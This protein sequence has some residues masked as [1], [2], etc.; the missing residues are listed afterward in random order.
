MPGRGEAPSLNMPPP[1]SVAV[2]E[3]TS[4]DTAIPSPASSSRSTAVSMLTAYLVEAYAPVPTATR[5][6]VPELTFTIRPKPCAR[7]AGSTAWV[8]ASKLTTLSCSACPNAARSVLSSG[9]CTLTPALLTSPSIRWCRAKVAVTRSLTWAGS[10]TSVATPSAPPSCWLS[11]ASRSARRAASTGWAPA[12]C[13]CR[14]VAA[15]IPD[16]APVTITVCPARSMRSVMGHFYQPGRGPNRA[17]GSGDQPGRRV[18]QPGPVLEVGHDQ[19]GR[20][21]RDHA[22]HG[23]A[24]RDGQRDDPAVP[25]GP[26]VLAAR[27]ELAA[28][29]GEGCR[30]QGGHGGRRLARL[31]RE[32]GRSAG[33]PEG[34]LG[35]VL[36]GQLQGPAHRTVGGHRVP[37]VA[38]HAP[39]PAPQIQGYLGAGDTAPVHLGDS[40]DVAA[41][42]AD[43]A[44]GDA[45]VGQDVR[46]AVRE[47]EGDAEH[48]QR[49]QLAVPP[50]RWGA[51][52]ALASP[53]DQGEQRGVP[54]RDRDDG[55]QPGA[56]VDRGAGA[57]AGHQFGA[58]RDGPVTGQVGLHAP[59]A[60]GPDRGHPAVG[61]ADDRAGPPGGRPAPGHVV[62]GEA[63]GVP[64]SAHLGQAGQAHPLGEAG[65]RGLRQLLP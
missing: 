29:D 6:V 23:V 17:A 47:A 34:G 48:R 38:G 9:P 37:A 43:A 51:G 35:Q 8:I 19:A 21:D 27:S 24:G 39:G 46:H 20:G 50:D 22:G 33:S 60:V 25:P 41:G 2:T 59:G 40:F 44:V 61:V 15:P 56:G 1:N 52:G 13:S 42:V 30:L 58:G 65:P 49:L 18:G 14:A 12:S 64:G 26:Q 57:V 45:A 31:Q 53:V 28:D 7:M 55:V 16:D 63:V 54:V 36:A 3:G 11:S 10:V 62:V 4:S 5:R 32:L